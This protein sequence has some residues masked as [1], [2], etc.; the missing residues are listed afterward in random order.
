MPVAPV[1]T[2]FLSADAASWTSVE[3]VMHPPSGRL[4]TVPCHDADTAPAV[5]TRSV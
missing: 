1:T 2:I 5:G 3:A 4:L